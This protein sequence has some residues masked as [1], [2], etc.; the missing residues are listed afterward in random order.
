MRTISISIIVPL[1]FFASMTADGQTTA[2]YSTPEQWEYKITGCLTES[3][4]NKLGLQ[5]WELVSVRGNEANCLNLFFKRPKGIPPLPPPP[6]SPAGPTCSM[7]LAQV[8]VINGFRLGM[9]TD[10]LL[11]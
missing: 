11:E 10:E 4:L 2:T 1:I 6:S 9:S 3:E 5:G 8:P 7:A